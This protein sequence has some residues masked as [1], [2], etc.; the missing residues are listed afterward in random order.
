MGDGETNAFAGTGYDGDLV[1][2]V[3]QVC[4][5]HA[6]KVH[7]PTH[8]VS[9]RRSFSASLIM[10][11]PFHHPATLRFLL[12]AVHGAEKLLE[13]PRYAHLDSGSLAMFLDATEAMAS[14][15]L[16]PLLTAMD[17]EGPRLEDGRIRVHP[18][19]RKLLPEFGEGGWISATGPLELGG[20]Q[21]PT[22]WSSAC[23]FVFGAANYS[24]T[25]FPY[26]A[27]GA[28]NLLVSFA[29]PSLRDRYL[30]HMWAGRWQGT[31]ALTEPE[32][33][34][35]LA[36]LRTT[37]TP[38]P[39]GG[40]RIQGQK[41]YISAGDHDAAENIVHLLLARIEGAPAGSKGISLFVVPRERQS[42]NGTLVP[43]DVQTAGLYHKMGYQ[44]APIA[45]LMFGENND[46][47]GHLVGEPNGGLT[48]MFQMMNE[49]RI[50][51]GLNAVSIASAAYGASRAYARVR[52]QGRP[53]TER[54]PSTPPI[55]ID[56]HA[57]VKRMLLQ[58]KAMVEGCLSLLIQC[59]IWADEHEAAPSPQK[60]RAGRLL[61]LMTPVAKSYPAESALQ[62]ISNGLQILG[63]AGYL[64][65][66]P[67]E[68][69]YREARIHPIHEGT[70]GIHGMDLLGR[71]IGRDQGRALREWLGVLE[72]DLVNAAETDGPKQYVSPYR[73]ALARLQQVTATLGQRAMQEGPAAFLAD[74]TLYLEAFG[75]LAVAWQ[76]LVIGTTAGR[77]LADAASAEGE[78]NFYRGKLAAMR[79]FLEYELPRTEA[80]FKRLE[81]QDRVTLETD[82]AWID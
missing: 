15:A 31:M 76:W 36:D 82:P 33:G 32:A 63:G 62:A 80:L 1:G 78:M 61:D 42:E 25:A 30:P 13:L 9:S 81:S 5:G 22:T 57:D 75:I 44:G 11:E 40:Y 54:D 46:C 79:Y 8:R 58:Q 50:A 72:A 68:Q 12:H 6:L 27:A 17:R 67:L 66:H 70:T 64:Q 38:M 48:C 19:M 26:L 29:E 60:E 47:I 3:Q 7:H 10:A 37:A 52:R 49:A 74:A 2:K 21:I 20:G 73:E 18:A 51:V 45:H 71:K 14:S 28:A 65:D 16:Q 69:F 55:P 53:L 41:I 35:S 59:S 23:L 4:V 43:N 34:S 77:A 56:Q 39:D 24:A